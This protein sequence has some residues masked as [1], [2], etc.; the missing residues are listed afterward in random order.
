MSPRKLKNVWVSDQNIRSLN[1]MQ[2][3]FLPCYVIRLY[4]W[5]QSTFIS[6][7]VLTFSQVS[8]QCLPKAAASE[9]RYLEQHALYGSRIKFLIQV[10]VIIKSSLHNVG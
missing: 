7:S 6:E 10:P 3:F 5:Q 2:V 8:V 4:K 9:R 1:L